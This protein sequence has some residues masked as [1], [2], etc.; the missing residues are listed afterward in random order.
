MNSN[1]KLL[2][3]VDIGGR[4][5]SLLSYFSDFK[6]NI[7]GPEDFAV[8]GDTVYILNS[9]DNTVLEFKNDKFICSHNAGLTFGIKVAAANG[10][11]YILRNDFSIMRIGADVTETMA[12]YNVMTEAIVDFMAL[13]DKLYIVIADGMAG[14]TYEFGFDTKGLDISKAKS[15]HGRIFDENTLY[16]T[17]LLA[18][19]AKTGGSGKVI[20]T[21]I[22]GGNTHEIPIHTNHFLSGAQYF[23]SDGEG[24]AYIKIYESETN[25]MYQTILESRISLVDTQGHEKYMRELPEQYKNITNQDK[26]IGGLIYSLNAFKNGVEVVMTAKPD[27]SSTREYTSCLDDVVPPSMPAE[28]MTFD[29]TKSITRDE[30]IKNAFD[31]H[32][33]KWSCTEANLL[34]LPGWEAPRFVMGPGDYTSMPYCW[35]GNSTME[36]YYAGMAAGGRVGNI[37]SPGPAL[38]PNT[39]GHDCSGFVGLCWGETQKYSTNTIQSIS[40]PISSSDLKTGDALDS[41]F[42]HIVLFESRDGWGNYILF[43]STVFSRFDSV[44]HTIRPISSLKNFIPLRYINVEDNKMQSL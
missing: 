43:E 35:G 21:D 11:L 42:Y 44:S 15:Y 38:V 34:P 3:S 37:N 4:G 9:I 30:I 22:S 5:N 16:E 29:P 1:D 19:D 39:F 33:F 18:Y 32:S 2:V 40:F 12:L 28:T 36:E 10:V 8:D 6:A 7:L 31:Y 24:G 27:E 23:G 25:E 17:R 26:S 20:I 13:G 14:I 41:P